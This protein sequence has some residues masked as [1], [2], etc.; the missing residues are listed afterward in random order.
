MKKKAKIALGVLGILCLFYL[1]NFW[2]HL[3]G[4]YSYHS[5]PLRYK[6][7]EVKIKAGDGHIA[8][9]GY[10]KGG[11]ANGYGRLFDKTGTLLYE[12]D[13]VENKYEGQ[14]TLYYPSG[15]IEYKGEFKD[16]QY[17]GTGSLY[18]EGGVVI[19]EGSFL[20]GQKEGSGIL[21]DEAGNLLY[22]GT[23]HL[24]EPVLEQFLNRSSID[25]SKEYEG[26]MDV[27]SFDDTWMITLDELSMSYEGVMDE[28]DTESGIQADA[29]YICKDQFILGDQKIDS[30]SEIKSVWGEPLSEGKTTLLEKED[31]VAEYFGKK[32]SST[33]QATVFFR[34]G[35]TY[36]FFSGQG[37]DDFFMYVIT[38]SVK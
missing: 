35:V 32:E 28:N 38:G 18:S 14:G 36:T 8:Y 17:S 9:E 7:G 34:E 16:N 13:F 5:I 15:A 6:D 37:K 33:C 11:Y 3:D 21:T 1:I 23:F 27:Q 2:I 24:D 31:Y 10:V 20:H 22:K 30:I 4:V 29:I 25:I 26:K 12:G 19:Y